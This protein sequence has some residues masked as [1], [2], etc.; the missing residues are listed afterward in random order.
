MPQVI[1][2]PRRSGK[3]LEIVEWLLDGKPTERFP[4]WSR[5]IVCNNDLS[6]SNV[7]KIVRSKTTTWRKTDYV[8]DVRRAIWTTAELMTNFDNKEFEYAID[9]AHLM[10]ELLNRASVISITGGIYAVP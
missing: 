10:S 3:T 5:V 4:Y 8:H 9:D 6:A 7:S 1:V 2:G